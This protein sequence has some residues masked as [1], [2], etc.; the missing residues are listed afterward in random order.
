MY[1]EYGLIEHLLFLSCVTHLLVCVVV[2][3]LILLC[4]KGN[5][6]CVP[7]L[8]LL[9]FLNI[10]KHH[11]YHETIHWNSACSYLVK[12]VSMHYIGT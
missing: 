8:F 3:T 11:V 10:T 6:Y 7:A 4:T 1:G 5:V 12:C 9:F 2:P